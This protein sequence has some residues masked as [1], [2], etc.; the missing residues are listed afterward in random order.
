MLI[1]PCINIEFRAAFIFNFKMTQIYVAVNSTNVK[2]VTS[3]III[4]INSFLKKYYLQHF[5]K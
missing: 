2:K 4:I 5:K 1:F 3:Y